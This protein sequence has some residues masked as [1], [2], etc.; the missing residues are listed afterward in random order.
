MTPIETVE[1]FIEGWN[2]MD[3]D[4]V[5]GLLADDVV[6]HNIP[7]EKLEGKTAA[8]AFIR[9]MQADAVDW[10]TLNIAANGAVV[11]TE[12]VDNFKM[13]Q[14]KDVSVPVMGI[15]E[16]ENGK[17]KAW[18]DYFDLNTFASQMA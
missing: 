9:G 3:W 1:A 16:I 12:R 15:F 5:I 14:G 2:Q 10:I 7:M 6:Y 18:R 11:L 4:T 17:I 13:S 8:E